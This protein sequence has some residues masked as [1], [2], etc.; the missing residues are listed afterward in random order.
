MPILKIHDTKGNINE[1]EVKANQNLLKVLLENSY[2]I[3]ANC[4]GKGICGKCKVLIEK[5]EGNLSSVE[6]RLLT[7]EDIQKGIR[8]SCMVDILD[9]MEIFIIDDKAKNARILKDLFR[10][11]FI[12]DSD[13]I[14]KE[15][16][17]K[18]PTLDD[19]KDYLGRL[20][21]ELKPYDIKILP[22]VLNRLFD[23]KDDNFFTIVY[24]DEVLDIKRD[25][26]LL[27]VAIDIGTTTVV[28][29]L[30]DLVEGCLID[31]YAFVNPQK[32]FGA[33]VISRIDFAKEN[34]N[35]LKILQK[36]ILNGVNEAIES[37]TEKNG[38][39]LKNIYKLIIVGNTTML[40]LFLGVCPQ[41]IAIAPF[42][43]VFVDKIELRAKDLGLKTN[44]NAI[45]KVLDGISS[46][47]GADIVAGIVTTE[48]HKEKEVSLLL[49][50][51]T[52][53]EM[54]L[55][56]KDF[57]IACS[58]AA[59]PAFEGVN[60]S[61]GMSAL[62]GAIDSIF[63]KD[64][65]VK[66]TV[67]G[68]KEPVGIC[69]SGVILAASYMLEEGIIDATGRFCEDGLKKY[70]RF[71]REVNNQLAF[72]ITD[73]IYITQK[74]IREIQLAKAAISAGIKTML[75]EANILVDDIENVYLS[76]GFGNYINPWAAIKIGLID[77]KLKD[78]IKP[79]GNS[80]GN[81]AILALLNKNVENEFGLI[82]NK[83][84]YIELSNSA[85]FNELFI[86]S[87]MF[88]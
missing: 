60:L 46:Y 40:H 15:I 34:E 70:E 77:Q 83:L 35:G 52:N 86:E 64:G 66:F 73:N 39:D 22:K 65:E 21:D 36:E 24:K 48:I 38:F 29:Y 47:V 53:G 49:D 58:T 56:N 63:I 1:I 50:L 19:Q 75:K 10:N 59:G 41:S 27:G 54:V 9:D 16:K 61:C 69:G 5:G 42:S 62:E 32:R 26:N 18:K 81:G 68:N 23:L 12:V 6:K 2:Q 45:V 72:F 44:E 13:I 55:G 37:M 88:D 82:K 11:D 4:N 7:K 20:K 43:P 28:L 8:L 14:I 67:I 31:T 78:R 51:G 80:A 57:L 17:L 85:E 87:M 25:K 76:G 33:D 79:V 74:D 30:F 3:E 71:F 84:Q